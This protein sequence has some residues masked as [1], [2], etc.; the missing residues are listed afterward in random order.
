MLSGVVLTTRSSSYAPHPISPKCVLRIKSQEVELAVPKPISAG[1]PELLSPSGNLFGM[2]FS[3]DGSDSSKTSVYGTSDGQEESACGNRP[4]PG[5][6][7][8]PSCSGTEM[9]N[10]ESSTPPR[11]SAKAPRRTKKATSSR[12][13][14]CTSHMEQT[15]LLGYLREDFVKFTLLNLPYWKENGLWHQSALSNPHR[16]KSGYESLE[17]IYTCVCELEMRIDDDPIRKRA[18]LVLLDSRYKEAL[19]EWKSKKLGKNK[20]SLGI[21]RGDASAMIDNILSSMHSGWDMFEAQ[22]KTELRAKFHDDKR[23]GKRWSIL[24]AGL[25]PSI[26]FLCS[27]QLAK[28]VYVLFLVLDSCR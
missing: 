3:L 8:T 17:S 10:P 19:E 28:L 26:L 20:A 23:F 22:R 7:P 5:L 12:N 1:P 6:L 16:G 24:V 9:S 2:G 14:A 4:F 15:I 25:G 13:E 21:G 27:P 11:V 18:A